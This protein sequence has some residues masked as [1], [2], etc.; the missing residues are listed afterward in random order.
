MFEGVNF[1]YCEWR[2]VA[3]EWETVISFSLRVCSR[4]KVLTNVREPL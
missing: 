2:N 1:F 3:T 4:D